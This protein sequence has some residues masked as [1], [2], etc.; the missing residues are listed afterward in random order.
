M[1]SLNKK[2][3]KISLGIGLGAG[4]LSIPVMLNLGVQMNLLRA[5][6]AVLFFAVFTPFGYSVAYW[7]SRWMPVA[8][9][10]VKFGIIGGFNTFFDL[11]ILNS[12]IY[13]TG[14]AQGW[15][16]TIF[17]SISFLTAVTNSYFWNK[18]WTFKADSQVE[19]GEFMKFLGVNIIG[20][21]INIG[22]ASFIVNGIGAPAGVSLSVWANVGALSATFISLFWNFIGMKFIVFKR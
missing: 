4:L 20:F 5:F 1:E 8:I 10:I 9:Q 22:I 13:I 12:L 21:L 14:L 7:L 6:E 18:Y 2:D 16:Y 11:G 17:K 19:G 3:L 15:P